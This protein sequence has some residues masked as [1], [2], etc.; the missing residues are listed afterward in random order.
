VP[1][2]D[3]VV[4]TGR[5]DQNKQEFGSLLGFRPDMDGYNWKTIWHYEMPFRED[6]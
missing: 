6:V 1:G 5:E 4:I 2:K 3:E